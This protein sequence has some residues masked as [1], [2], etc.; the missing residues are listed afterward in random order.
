MPTNQ[1]PISVVIQ[2]NPFE[3]TALT[4]QLSQAARTAV[5]GP[6]VCGPEVCTPALGGPALGGNVGGIV[7]FT[8]HCRDE[9]GTLAALE[10]EHYPGMAEAEITRI[11]ADA[12]MRWPLF[13]AQIVHRYGKIRPGEAIVLVSCASRHRRAA[14]QGAEFIMDFLKTRAPFWKK[15]HRIDGS[16]TAWVDARIEDDA[17]EAR[18]G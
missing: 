8:G 13:N 6:A 12:A 10:L 11:A 2:A 4:A 17:A 3:P 1:C 7:T 9:D 16:C 14:F 18:W 15:E 5:S